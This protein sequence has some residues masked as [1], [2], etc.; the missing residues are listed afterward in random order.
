VLLDA[1][2]DICIKRGA[3]FDGRGRV[4]RCWLEWE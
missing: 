3:I 2:L 1:D 4:F